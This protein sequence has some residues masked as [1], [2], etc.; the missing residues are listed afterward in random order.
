MKD[1]LFDELKKSIKE[2]GRIL[3]GKSKAS[4]EFIKLGTRKKKAGRSG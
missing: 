3:K 2:G 1:E 4:R